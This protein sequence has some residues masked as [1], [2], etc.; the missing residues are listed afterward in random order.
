M[1]AAQQLFSQP[2]AF[3]IHPQRSYRIDLTVS[4]G[5]VA[6]EN[7]IRR[8]VYQ[9]NIHLGADTGQLLHCAC[10]KVHAVLALF[11]RS[12]GPIEGGTINDVVRL[13]LLQLLT[14]LCGLGDIKL[15]ARQTDNIKK[16]IRARLA[17]QLTPDLAISS[18]NQNTRRPTEIITAHNPIYKPPQGAENSEIR[19]CDE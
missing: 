19:E 12:I 7:V 1:C 15:P 11:L 18:R 4:A 9:G 3:T 10:I 5:I 2:L 16:R 8:Q 14:D 17:D 13:M 6:I